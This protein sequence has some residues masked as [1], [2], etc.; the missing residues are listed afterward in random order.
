MYGRCFCCCQMSIRRKRWLGRWLLIGA[1][2]MHERSR[3]HKVKRLP[4]N[5][6]EL[7]HRSQADKGTPLTKGFVAVEE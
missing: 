4:V 3:R 2:R 7:R 1:K 5:R 6:I